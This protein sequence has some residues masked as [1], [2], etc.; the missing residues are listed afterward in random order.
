MPDIEFTVQ[1]GV[2]FILQTRSGKR[3]GAAAVKIAVD[4]EQEGIVS[5]SRA[6]NL[7]SAEHIEILLHKQFQ[8]CD[9]PAYK[10]AVL[11]KGLPASPGA[12]VGVIAFTTAEAERVRNEGKRAILVREETSAEDVGGMAAADGVLTARGGMTSHAAVV[13]RGWGKVLVNRSHAMHSLIFLLP[14]CSPV[15]AGSESCGLT[16]R[17]VR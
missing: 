11:G 8:D 5:K 3:G 16:E 7:V 13:T 17:R 12:V 9:T 2:L 6:I 4:L 15:Y 1:E 14:S 10:E